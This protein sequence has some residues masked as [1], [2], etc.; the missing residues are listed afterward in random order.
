MAL[1][2]DVHS[3]LEVVRAQYAYNSAKLTYQRKFNEAVRKRFGK[4]Q[5]A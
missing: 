1:W 4:E 5:F 2:N 3:D